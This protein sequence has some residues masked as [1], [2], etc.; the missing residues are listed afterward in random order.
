M[1]EPPVY[2][3]AQFSYVLPDRRFFRSGRGGAVS[4]AI[5]IID[6][7]HHNRALAN[8]VVGER[9]KEMLIDM[10]SLRSDTIQEVNAAIPDFVPFAFEVRALQA[11]IKSNANIIL[12]RKTWRSLITLFM[13]SRPLPGKKLIAEVNGLSLQHWRNKRLGSLVY[14]AIRVLHRLA[15][16]QVDGVYVVSNALKEE[17]VNGFLGLPSH[18]VRVIPNG[19]PIRA[20]GATIKP[21]TPVRFVYFGKFQHY[22]EFQNLVVAFDHA[23]RKSPVACELVF[24]GFGPEDPTIRGL[25]N[26]TKGV[27][28]Y[29]PMTIGSLAS[30]GII[31]KN[32]WGVV[33]VG[34]N[35][36]AKYLS[37]IK[38]FDYLALGMPSIVSSTVDLSCADLSPE[39]LIRYQAGDIPD[40]TKSLLHAATSVSAAPPN[41]A[42]IKDNLARNSWKARMADLVSWVERLD[43]QK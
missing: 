7:L 15:L 41:S 35:D 9:G 18:R 1:P 11:A 30:S 24:V 8:V 20:I 34:D 40:L 16:R 17:L 36:D 43:D 38:L 33:P 28:A 31:T 6:G 23:R 4:H 22:N 21:D 19:S 32:S 14:I 25:A 27:F 37:P 5:G 2:R 42:L 3:T 12:F 26:A 13:L 39:V 29:G 10:A